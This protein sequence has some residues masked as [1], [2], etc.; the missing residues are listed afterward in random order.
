MPPR[1][2]CL[3]RR[4]FAAPVFRPTSLKRRHARNKNLAFHPCPCRGIEQ[5]LAAPRIDTANIRPFAQR[6]IIGGM[7]QQIDAHQYFRRHILAKAKTPRF[8]CG[9]FRRAHQL[10]D[11]PARI[12]ERAAQN[13]ADKSI[14]SCNGA[15]L[16]HASLPS[17]ACVAM[18]AALAM[19]V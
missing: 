7:N 12:F 8:A 19:I 5:F 6:E 11:A 2:R 16:G 18:R 1:A 4:Q 14:G 10:D 13:T 17:L 9:L 15:N 3:F